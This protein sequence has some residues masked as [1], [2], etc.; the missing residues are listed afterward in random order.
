MERLEVEEP[1]Y[2]IE[3]YPLE[4]EPIKVA[5]SQYIELVESGNAF[6]NSH[7]VAHFKTIGEELTL[8]FFEDNPV[9]HDFLL[10]RIF[11]SN[12]KVLEGQLLTE[13]IFFACALMFPDMT[14]VL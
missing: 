14:E 4:I 7:C 11:R 3:Y 5:L 12:N 1:Q 2:I 9:I 10:R 13:T 6:S 8:S